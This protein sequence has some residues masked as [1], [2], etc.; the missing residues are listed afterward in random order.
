MHFEEIAG[1][2]RL[3]SEKYPAERAKGSSK[4]YSEYGE[5]G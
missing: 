4:K 5:E 3:N 1:K 2:I